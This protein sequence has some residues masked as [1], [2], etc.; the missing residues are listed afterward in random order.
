MKTMVPGGSPRRFGAAWPVFAGLA[1]IIAAGGAWI[2]LRPIAPPARDAPPQPAP[3]A[4]AASNPAA[5]SF[6][7][8]RVSPDGNA[9]IAGRAQPGAQVTVR[10]GDQVLGQAQAD[11]SGAFVL[12]PATPLPP[13]GQTLTLASRDGSAAEIGGQSSVVVV[14]PS[15]QAPP[16]GPSPLL[17]AVALMVPQS[18]APTLLR[19]AGRT[20]Q[21]LGLDTVDYDERGEIRFSGTAPPAAPVRVYVDNM[22][23]GEAHADAHGQWTLTPQQPVTAGVH[24]FRLDQ[25]AASGQVAGRVELPF[26]RTALPAVNLAHGRVIVQP[27][28][29][30]W[31]I[32]R[33]AYGSGIRYTVIYLANRE[34]IRDPRRIYPGQVFATPGMTP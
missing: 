23:V 6:D 1:I 10:N 5:P 27:G 30:L 22:P 16:Q 25:L 19:P 3:A 8:V 18:G 14:V 13:G 26:Q 21:P 4:Q 28:E 12:V 29:N 33:H 20:G 34:Q 17:P 7:V 11:R 9:V 24:R 31:R 32:A 2:T 15:K